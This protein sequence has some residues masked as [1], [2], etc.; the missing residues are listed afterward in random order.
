MLCRD[1]DN[2]P[3]GPPIIEQK[4]R[5]LALKPHEVCIQSPEGQR[6]LRE[7]HQAVMDHVTA[8]PTLRKHLLTDEWARE[9]LNKWLADTRTLASFSHPSFYMEPWELETGICPR[10]YLKRADAGLGFIVAK[11]RKANRN[12]LIGN[13][14]RGVSAAAEFEVMLAWALSS[15]FGDDGVEP[16]PRIGATN[17]KT[18]EFAICRGGKCL[19][20]EAMILL[21]DST[22]GQEKQFCIEHGI[23]GTFKWAN[24]EQDAHRLLKACHDKVH[25]RELTDPLFLCVNQWASWPDPATGAEVVGRLLASEI[26]A[27]DSTFVGMAYFYASHLVASGFAEA[28]ALATGANLALLSEV[29]SALC[30]LVDAE[31]LERVQAKLASPGARQG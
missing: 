5:L 15:H 13:L 28:R 31:S 2:E 17:S 21:D 7:R 26:W 16:Y 22:S 3:S 29:R 30:R 24:G 23:P 18:V 14:L 19:L 4:G 9:F 12:D 8:Y 20:I 1:A 6:W 27:R 10:D 25:Q 11:A